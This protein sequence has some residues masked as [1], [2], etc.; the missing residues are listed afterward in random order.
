VPLL[1]VENQPYI[2]YRKGAV[3]L[4]LLRDYIG[5]DAVDSALRRFLDR[6]RDAGPPYPTSR[7]LYA[8]LRAVTPDSLQSLLTDLFE[9]VT[10]WDVRAKR[11][12]AEP[13]GSGGYRVTLDVE[14]RKVRADSL[15]REHE[16]PMDDLVEIGVFGPDSG[17]HRGDPLHLGRH[18][19]HGGA[20]TITVT[21]P[22]KPARAGIDPRHM[23]IDRDGDDN[24]ADV[25][26]ATSPRQPGSG[27]APP[28]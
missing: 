6:Y 5:E 25:T 9:T 10:L 24:V 21:V 22:R 19:V 20:Q 8:E 11:A 16:V 12:V 14:A 26:V 4:Y 13:T 1:D 18:R 27:P 23:L 3:A 28:P 2:M 15:G 7:E 17:G